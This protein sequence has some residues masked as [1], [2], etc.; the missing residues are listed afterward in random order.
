M[1]SLTFALLFSQLFSEVDIS[2]GMKRRLQALSF[3]S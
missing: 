1:M 2:T 3:N